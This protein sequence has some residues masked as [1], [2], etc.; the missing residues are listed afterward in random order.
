MVDTKYMIFIVLA[1][2][3]LNEVNESSHLGKLMIK[4]VN[5]KVYF[6]N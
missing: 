3:S 5:I 4:Q 1:I 6:F 2:H